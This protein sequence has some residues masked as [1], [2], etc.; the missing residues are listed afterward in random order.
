MPLKLHTLQL[1]LG[2]RQARLIH[3]QNRPG[4]AVSLRAP[5]SGCDNTRATHSPRAYTPQ[6]HV[7]VTRSPHRHTLNLHTYVTTQP[8]PL[9]A[10]RQ[11]GD[12]DRHAQ[13]DFPAV[14]QEPVVANH[15]LR[16]HVQG[17]VDVHVTRGDEELC[18]GVDHDHVACCQDGREQIVCGQDAPGHNGQEAHGG[19]THGEDWETRDRGSN[20]EN[21]DLDSRS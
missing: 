21:C 13:S 1:H 11:V 10:A 19:D 4:E 5:D 8:L 14:A 20:V 2:K 6:L 18:H 7:C 3:R 9:H 12:E 15:V 16:I 17:D